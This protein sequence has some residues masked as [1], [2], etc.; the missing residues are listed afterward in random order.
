MTEQQQ[1]DELRERVINLE[2]RLHDLVN[3]V[4]PD[5][6]RLGALWLDYKQRKQRLGGGDEE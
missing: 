5:H 4:N 2:N 1:I 3:R 6:L